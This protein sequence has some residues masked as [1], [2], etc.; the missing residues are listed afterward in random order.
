MLAFTT[1]E[2]EQLLRLL[3]LTHEAAE[4]CDLNAAG[5][6]SMDTKSYDEAGGHTQTNPIR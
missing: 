1:L 4:Q 6:L 3:Q 2:P 5:M